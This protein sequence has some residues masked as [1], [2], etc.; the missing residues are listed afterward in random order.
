MRVTV[1]GNSRQ[2]VQFRK[3]RVPPYPQCPYC[4][5]QPRGGHAIER[6]PPSTALNG[7]QAVP[8]D[9]SRTPRRLGH[10]NPRKPT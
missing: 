1:R 5:R 9:M 7:V 6:S 4:V 10:R 2:G 3:R 8:Q